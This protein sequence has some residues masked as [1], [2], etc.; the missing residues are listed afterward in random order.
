MNNNILQKII[1]NR[2]KEIEKKKSIMPI[3]KLED[4]IFD[5]ENTYK[6]KFFNFKKKISDNIKSDKISII[7]EIKK[8][9]PSA[10][11]II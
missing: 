11:I 4:L 6:C 10:G 7:G 3:K 5:Y 1:D 8:A 9:S 2:I